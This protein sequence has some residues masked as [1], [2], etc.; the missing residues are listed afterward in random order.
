MLDADIHGLFEHTDKRLEEL[1]P[2]LEQVAAELGYTVEFDDESLVNHHSKRIYLQKGLESE[3]LRSDLGHELGHC[4]ARE[5]EPKSWNEVIRRNH[6]SVPDMQ[7]HRETLTDHQGDRLTMPRNIVQTVI[8][9]CG[10]NARAVWVLHQQQEVYLHE[11]LRRLVH[12]NENAR[13]GG[14]IARRGTITHAYSYRYRLPVWVGWPMP[15]PDDEFQGEGVSLFEV[16][17][18][19]NTYIGLVVIED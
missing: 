12:F 1:G 16:P 4:L 5:G 9:I 15:D 6:A 7:A 10:L 2:S 11:A 13:I 18:L 3:G 14:F 8:N 17:A 19:P